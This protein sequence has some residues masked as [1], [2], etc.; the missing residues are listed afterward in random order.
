MNQPEAPLRLFVALWPDEAVRADC[1]RAGKALRVLCGGRPMQAA[2]LHV[3]LA[4]LG[5]VA[6]SRLPELHTVLDAMPPVRGM[7]FLDRYG[8]WAP[9][10]VWLGPT[11]VDAALMD[12][13]KS[14]RTSLRRS[15]FT[16]D[17]KTFKPHLTLL[18]HASKPA[19]WPRAQPVIWAFAGASLVVSQA[20][21]GGA[22]YRICQ[23]F[24]L[25]AVASS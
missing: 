1:A 3:T 14:L 5:E 16:L 6:A 19:V 22:G 25:P 10:I 24:A 4:F 2:G 7:L 17:G 8:Y 13:V 23:R 21:A 12:W 11:D 18:R 20:A 9:G 15:G